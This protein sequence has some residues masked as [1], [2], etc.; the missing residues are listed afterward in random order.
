MR[1]IFLLLVCIGL[2]SY[3]LYLQDVIQDKETEY[4]E[5]I[6]IIETYSLDNMRMLQSELNTC[7]KACL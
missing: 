6:K 4:K 5:N 7:K 3:I 2:M 1:I